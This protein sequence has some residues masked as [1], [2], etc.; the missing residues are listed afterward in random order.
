MSPLQLVQNVAPAARVPPHLRTTGQEAQTPES[1]PAGYIPPHLRGFNTP[2]KENAT[3]NRPIP[4]QPQVNFIPAINVQ[5]SEHPIQDIQ[6]QKHG[7][8]KNPQVNHN[9]PLVTQSPAVPVDESAMYPVQPISGAKRS[10]EDRFLA[11]MS[12]KTTRDV[13]AKKKA[14]TEKARLAAVQ[15]QLVQGQPLTAGA[16]QS[17]SELQPYILQPLR[18][19]FRPTEQSDKEMQAF[20]INKVSGPVSNGKKYLFTGGR[21]SPQTASAASKPAGDGSKLQVASSSRKENTSPFVKADPHSAFSPRDLTAKITS[22][23]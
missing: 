12:Q 14:V 10:P 18:S 17:L 2:L 4:S 19:K 16:H 15:A 3:L 23:K 8:F 13:E 22:V 1:K 6:F 5:Q 11:F 9:I 7:M 20:L 21:E